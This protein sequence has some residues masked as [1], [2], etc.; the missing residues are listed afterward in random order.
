M[1]RGD[2][3]GVDEQIKVSLNELITGNPSADILYVFEKNQDYETIKE[4]ILSDNMYE[5]DTGT[6]I[7]LRVR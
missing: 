2:T 3:S 1:A 7:V 5:I 4:Y 6:E